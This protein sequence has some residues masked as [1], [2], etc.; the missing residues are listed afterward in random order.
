MRAVTAAETGTMMKCFKLMVQNVCIALVL[1][2]PPAAALHAQGVAAPLNRP[3]TMTAHAAQSAL[4]DLAQAGGRLVAVGERG[5]VVLSDDQGKTWRQGRSPVSVTLTAVRF[6]DARQGWA[7][8]HAGVVLH[9]A[10][11]GENWVRQLDGVQAARLALEAAKAGMAAEA[12]PRAHK[13]LDQAEQLVK[14]GADKPFFDLYFENDKTGYVVGAYNMFF[15]TN[16]GGKSW[17]PLSERLDNPTDAHLYA[18]R[19]AGAKL[20]IAGEQGLLLRSDDSARSFTRLASPYQ[21]SY[22]ALS[23]YPSGE[24]IA[25]G[26]RGNAYRS[27]DHGASWDK[28]ELGAQASVLATALSGKGRLLLATQAGQILESQD[29]GRTLRAIASNL[30]P[31]TQLAVLRDDSL[32][33]TSLRGVLRIPAQP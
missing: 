9:S 13:R 17:Q 8:G 6:I 19:A 29:R 25:A 3:A 10:D 33:A 30:P 2:L 1:A 32:V 23:A 16:D 28:L 27:T 5:I 11:G 18:I 12:T 31:L 7:V 21:G 20:Y 24:L 4:M 14:D 26:L 15:G 22:F